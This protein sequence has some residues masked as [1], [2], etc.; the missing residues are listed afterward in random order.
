MVLEWLPGGAGDDL[1][2]SRAMQQ[3]SS[4]TTSASTRLVAR[5]QAVEAGIRAT[6]TA[7]ARQNAWYNLA[8]LLATGGDPSAVERALRNSIAC[9]PTWFKPHWALAKLLEITHRHAEAIVEA[10]AAVER[11]GGKDAEV[12][13]TWNRLKEGQAQR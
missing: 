4:N 2:Y 9:A 5:G 3:L 7:E 13:E 8:T 11:D 1:D 12:T 6:N 10:Q